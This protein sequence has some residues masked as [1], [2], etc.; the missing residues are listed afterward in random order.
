[1]T[2]LVLLDRPEYLN[3]PYFQMA[4]PSSRENHFSPRYQVADQDE[5]PEGLPLADNMSA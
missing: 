5:W 3:I 4:A 1:M 2:T